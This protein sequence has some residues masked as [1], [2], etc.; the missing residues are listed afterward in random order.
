MIFQPY[1][2]VEE[3]KHALINGLPSDTFIL[4][5]VQGCSVDVHSVPF[6]TKMPDMLSFNVE[7]HAALSEMLSELEKQLVIKKCT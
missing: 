2:L 7:E 3:L 6:Q 4:Q 1:L 5:C